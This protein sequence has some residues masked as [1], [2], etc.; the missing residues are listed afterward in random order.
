MGKASRTGNITGL[1]I[2]FPKNKYLINSKKLVNKN[3]IYYNY[4]NT[5]PVFVN[6]CQKALEL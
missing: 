4:I 2:H 1:F 3:N 6:K 5:F